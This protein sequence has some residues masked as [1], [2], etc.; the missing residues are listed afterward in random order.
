[1]V[2]LEVTTVAALV[3]VAIANEVTAS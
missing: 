3:K 1:M 2:K